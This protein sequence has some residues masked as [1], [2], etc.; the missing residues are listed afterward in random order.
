MKRFFSVFFSL[1]LAS[2]AS[3]GL[4]AD[5]DP[6]A[7]KWEEETPQLPGF[8]KEADLREFFVSATTPHRYFIDTA[9]LSVGK[10]GVVRYTL[11]VHTRGGVTNITYEGLRCATGQFKIYAT[12]HTDGRWVMA[13]QSAWRPIE[14][15]PT[16]RHHAALSHDYF[17]PIGNPIATPEEGREALRLGKHPSVN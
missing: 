16:Y 15:N 7:P 1:F 11:V 12:G 2:N 4:F 6:D 3:A 10:D 14:N 17:C 9:S 8:P 13:R 5:E